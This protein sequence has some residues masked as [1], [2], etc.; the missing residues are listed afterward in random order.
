[1]VLPNTLFRRQITEHIRLLMID[2]THTLV[3]TEY[4]VELK[5]LFQ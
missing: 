4:A 3:L 1:M 2:S 5:W